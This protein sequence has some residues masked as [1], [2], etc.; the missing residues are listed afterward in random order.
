[1][2]K[3]RIIK[4]QKSIEKH[5]KAT[6]ENDISTVTREITLKFSENILNTLK[7]NFLM[8]F[9]LFTCFCVAFWWFSCA[10]T[11]LKKQWCKKKQKKSTKKPKKRVLYMCN[12]VFYQRCSNL[13]Q[14][15][16]KN[17]K[18]KRK[19]T[20]NNGKNNKKNN[21]SSTKAPL[22]AQNRVNSEKL[23]CFKPAVT[24]YRDASNLN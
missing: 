14:K 22:K 9:M 15:K 24:T 23:N 4:A 21:K 5:K 16:S 7:Q 11:L 17:Q 8:L 20:K 10:L 13:N 2:H 1:M 3:K 12:F 19:S 6:N 18:K